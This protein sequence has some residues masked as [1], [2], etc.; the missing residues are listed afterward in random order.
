MVVCRKPGR[1]GMSSWW[2]GHYIL[3]TTTWPPDYYRPL[4]WRSEVCHSLIPV[5]D[6]LTRYRFWG[7]AVHHAGAG[8][9]PIPIKTLT[10]ENL[11]AALKFAIS[12]QAVAAVGILGEKIR[13][14][15]GEERGVISFARNMPVRDMWYVQ[16]LGAGDDML[17]KSSCDIDPRRVAVWWCNRYCLR[18]SIDAAAALVNAQK[19]MYSDLEPYRESARIMSSRGWANEFRLQS[20]RHNLSH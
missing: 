19:I 10:V 8:P 18:L 12:E 3:W 4:L 5:W 7:D 9:A 2:G 15:K 20:I 1:G 17:I 16:F 13:S 14:E 11:T 6:K